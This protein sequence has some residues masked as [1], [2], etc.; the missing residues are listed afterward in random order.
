MGDRYFE[1]SVFKAEIGDYIEIKGKLNKVIGYA[2]GDDGRPCYVVDH[3][4]DSLGW[5]TY[6][7]PCEKVEHKWE[8]V[9][10]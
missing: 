1:K 5:R 4:R 3:G 9:K 7:Q 2:I 8:L 10:L 6:L